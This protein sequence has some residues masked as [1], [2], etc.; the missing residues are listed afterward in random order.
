[1]VAYKAI[2]K[3][4]LASVVDDFSSA[5][6]GWQVL[7]KAVVYR[8]CG[9]IRQIIWFQALRT[10]AYRPMHGI[11]AL[12]QPL[13]RML[14]Q[15]LDVRN[16]ETKLSQHSERLSKMLAAMEQQFQPAIRK[17]LDIAEVAK[18]CEA[19]ARE[20]TNDLTM[21][22]VLHAWLGH[23]T[24]A[25]DYCERLQHC[26]M[27]TLAPIPEWEEEMRSFGRSLARAVQAGTE[28]TFLEKAAESTPEPS[29]GR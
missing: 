22:A 3:K 29:C 20:T 16:R 7:G 24:E 5:L 9:P 26:P 4:E 10:G 19:E 6:P 1:M 15:M 2:T 27:P 25:L 23:K 14:P 11:S 18:L 12:S 28:Q 8:D 17:P 13:A 21:L